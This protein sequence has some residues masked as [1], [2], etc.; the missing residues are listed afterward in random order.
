MRSL[1]ATSLIRSFC[2]ACWLLLA[3]TCEAA[4]PNKPVTEYTHTVWTHKDGIPSAFIHAIAQTSDGYLWLATTDGLVRFDGVR[5]VH[6]RPKT[7]H[8][9]L[10]GVVRSLCAARD[11]SL[12]IGTATGLIG[13]IRGDDLTA[14]S[15]G[16]QIEAMLE[17]H[18]GTL[19]VTLENSLLRFRTATQEQIGT[20]ITLPGPLLSGPLQD[21]S[22]FIWI[23]TDGGVLRLNTR[24]PQL[25]LVTTNKGKFWLS[26]DAGGAV[27]MT[28]TS[29]LTRPLSEGQTSSR[30]G[31]A[32]NTLNV[33]AVLHDSEGNMW[34]GTLGQGLVRL[35]ADS[36]DVRKME[37][38]SE[39]DG[40]ST[41]FVWCLLED[42]EHNVWVGTQNGLNRFRDEKITTLTRREGLPSDDVDALAAGPNGSIWASTA[43]GVSRIDGEHRDV[44]LRGTTI[45]GLSTDRQNTLWAGTNRGIVRTEDG[46]WGYLPMPAEIRLQ[47][48]TVI[49]EDRQNSVWLFDAR[50]GLYRWADNRITDF[51]NESLLKGKSVLA[52]AADTRGNVWFGLN[53]GGVVVFDGSLFRSYLESDGLAGGSVN[54]VH[55]DDNASV[56]IGTEHGLSRFEGLRFVTWNASSLPGE[57]V[58]W[59]LSDNEGRIWLGTAPGSP[60]S[61]YPNSTAHRKTR[62][63]AWPIPFSMMV[64]V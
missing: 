3:V 29:G 39:R 60:A 44:Y 64:T 7:G 52:A 28:D 56:W 45:M 49:A 51:S 57:R 26:E 4:N 41:Q 46:K 61:H 59:T 27:W 14:S 37:K 19:W 11:G 32:R 9:A 23:S 34:I 2:A 62:R 30:G 58:L 8:T 16:A 18:D 40:L 12:W 13:H 33:R 50:S 22:G 42:R 35:R 48:V 15:V 10:L 21:K 47:N 38:F 36:N 20:V 24:D 43:N 5:F 54:A 17:D 55:I 6:W 1:L 63:T 25:Q 31:M 53:E